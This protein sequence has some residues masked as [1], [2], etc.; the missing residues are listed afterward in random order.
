MK[1]NEFKSGASINQP[2]L[3]VQVKEGVTNSGAPYLSIT[4]R[5]NSGTI[6]GKL[7]DVKEAQSSIIK[8]AKVMQVRGDVISYRNAL[9]LKVIDV[10][11]V[12][13]ED[14]DM[15][16]FVLSGPYS[17]NQLRTGIDEAIKSIQN[18]EIY[19]IVAEIYRQYDEQIFS[20]AAAAKNHHEYYGGLATHIYSMLKLADMLCIN[21]P[22]LNRDLLT[23]GV[24]LHDV[25]KVIELT[26]TAV[27]EYTLEGKLLGHRNMS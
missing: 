13:S 8:A 25:G 6:E 24:L 1:I 12:N 15:Q 7:W 19:R 11:E 2:L 22:Y 21:Y 14:I 3:I 9:Q 23:A 10:T 4:F 16:E 27:A 17:T 5:D 20:S 26:N 18:Q